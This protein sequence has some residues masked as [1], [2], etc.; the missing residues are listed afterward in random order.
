MSTQSNLH[1]NFYFL[2]NLIPTLCHKVTYCLLL[3]HN[4][5]YLAKH[6]T[7]CLGWHCTW[8]SICWKRRGTPRSLWW[9]RLVWVHRHSQILTSS[10]DSYIVSWSFLWF[11]AISWCSLFRRERCKLMQDHA[12]KN[13]I[14]YY[15]YKVSSLGEGVWDSGGLHGFCPPHCFQLTFVQFAWDCLV[16]MAVVWKMW[17]RWL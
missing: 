15:I 10:F 14:L 9:L 8:G 1:F 11:P 3:Y 13:K 2:F 16:W 4:V 17:A 5:A 7:A 12:R 6:F